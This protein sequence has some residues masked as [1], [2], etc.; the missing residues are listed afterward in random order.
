MKITFLGATQTVTGSK[1]HLSFGAH[2]NVLVDCGLFQGLKA[3]RLRNWDALP[4]NPRILDYVLLTHAHIDHSGYLPLLVKNGFHGKILATPGTYDLCR[5]LLPDSAHLQEEDALHAN[6]HQ[7]SKHHPALPLYTINDAMNALKLFHPHPYLENHRLFPEINVK[8]I[9]AGHIIG[10]SFVKINAHGTTILFTGDMGRMND[11]VMKS[12]TPIDE[13]D[14][15]VVES[16]YGDRL[17]EKEHPKQL[18]KRII[19]ETFQRGGS[20]IIPAFAVGR[21][22]AM[23]HYLAELKNEG[24]LPDMPIYLDSPMAISATSILHKHHQDIKLT[25]VECDELCKIAICTNQPEDSMK[26]DQ[27]TRPKIIISASGMAT[28]GRVLFHLQKYAPDEKNTILFTGYQAAGTRGDRILQGEKEVKIHGVMVPIR[29][30]V[31]VL[32]N[33]SAHADYEEMMTWLKQFKRPPKLTFIT[34]GEPAAALS[35]KEKIENTLGWQCIIP[36]YLETK[37]LF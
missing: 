10:A 19:D 27:D 14:Y 26:I 18:L 11:P 23:L 12:P 32:H 24:L 1:Y 17:H 29:A 25:P 6:R 30:E 37:A 28:G 7:Y 16:T 35:L 13:V 3:L 20:I 15:L 8:F 22:Q 9:P 36:E 31:K 4:L 21:A 34:H 5:I 33:V 2:Q